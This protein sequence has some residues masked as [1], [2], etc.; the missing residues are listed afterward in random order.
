MNGKLRKGAGIIPGNQHI[1][2]YHHGKA[3]EGPLPQHI[4][5]RLSGQ[6]PV[7]ALADPQAQ[8]FRC[9]AVPV[10]KELL[11]TAAGQGADQFPGGHARVLPILGFQQPVSC[12]KVKVA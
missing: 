2:R 8:L 9:F 5:Q 7:H 6:K 3:V 4:G 12:L 1:G 10:H 11:L